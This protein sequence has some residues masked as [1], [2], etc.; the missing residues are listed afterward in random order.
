MVAVLVMNAMR[1]H[2][3]DRPAFKRQRSADGEGVLQPLGNLVAAMRQQS[4]VAHANTDVDRNNIGENGHDQGAPA[5][6]KERDNRADMKDGEEKSRR[7]GQLVLL[8]DTA[9]LRH[10]H[11]VLRCRIPECARSDLRF[12]LYGRNSGESRPPGDISR[13]VLGR[14]N[15]RRFDGEREICGSRS[16]KITS[17]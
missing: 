12:D 9:H 4:V 15:L 2:P 13:E 6:I 17:K 10:F 3:E 1:G 11:R 7:R 16:H 5:E 8:P 14:R